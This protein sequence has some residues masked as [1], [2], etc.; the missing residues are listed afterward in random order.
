MFAGIH[1]SLAESPGRFVTAMM[2]VGLAAIASTLLLSAA[3]PEM[4]CVMAAVVGGVIGPVLSAPLMWVLVVQPMRRDLSVEGARVRS[5]LEA[6]PDGIVGLDASGRIT[7]ANGSLLRMFGYAQG[8]LIGQTIERLV[9]GRF[10]EAH[11]GWRTEYTANPSSTRRMDASLTVQGLHRDGR[12]I[13]VEVSLNHLKDTRDIHVIAMV[14]DVTRKREAA[15]A[16]QR[17][18]EELQARALDLE[19]RE[20]EVRRISEMSDMLQSCDSEQEAFAIFARYSAQLF[21]G[22]TGL[23]YLTS[24][25]RNIMELRSEWG[26]PAVP[27]PAF[28]APSECWA[29]RRGRMHVAAGEGVRVECQHVNA[30]SEGVHLCM[31][32]VAHGETMGVIHL[33]GLPGTDAPLDEAAQR[34][35]VRQRQ[36][37][38]LA[39]SGQIGLALANLRFREALRYQSIRDPLTGLFNRRFLD[40]WL[41]R[42]L[43]RAERDRSSVALLMLDLD[44]FKRFNDTFGH[45]GGDAVLREVGKALQEEVR[46]S[47]IACRFGG[48]ELAIV[49]PATGMGEAIALAE[50]VRRRV[51]ALVV[52]ANGRSFGRI[53]LSV[54]VSTS[55]QHE[56]NAEKLIRAADH[57][58]Y[59]AK[60]GG[61]NRVVSVEAVDGAAVAAATG[62]RA[63]S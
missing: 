15:L 51:E 23:L 39:V 5:L 29:M 12:E 40:E 45:E 9:P 57:A 42:E 22:D 50:R 26:T 46:S 16:L 55:S 6:A 36:R 35:A 8:E 25:S 3:V 18:N 54:G 7:I 1:K 53:T 62:E 44:H 24:A 38:L 20:T 32:L 4:S 37:L 63:S 59:R 27:P 10:A 2:L 47:D 48:E 33:H 52:M 14:R 17:Q 49:A 21:P 41:E 56:Q 19:R 11:V 28:F 31:P 43:R 34:L 58:L 60:H 61:R 30:G 13:P